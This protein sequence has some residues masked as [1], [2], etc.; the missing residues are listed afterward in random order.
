MGQLCTKTLHM[1]M[2][3]HRHHR[4]QRTEV[5][6]SSS[7]ITGW[8][9]LGAWWESSAKLTLIFTCLCDPGKELLWLLSIL[10]MTIRYVHPLNY[11]HL[12]LSLSLTHTHTHTY[13][14][15]PTKRHIFVFHLGSGEGAS[16]QKTRS[17]LDL[18]LLLF[19]SGTFFSDPECKRWRP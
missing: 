7:A 9:Y 2:H 5:E 18:L 3:L 6:K 10:M 15:K 1:A 19:L 11:G 8:T 13:T 17:S 12:S 14:H 16:S 4:H